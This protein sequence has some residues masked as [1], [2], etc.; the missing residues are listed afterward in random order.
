MKY[1]PPASTLQPL[2]V[3]NELLTIMLKK[4]QQIRES[5]HARNLQHHDLKLLLYKTLK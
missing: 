2:L 4:R 3:S 1:P 5:S